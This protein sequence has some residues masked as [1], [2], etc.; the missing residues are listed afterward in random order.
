MKAT[1]IRTKPSHPKF[2]RLA[3]AGYDHMRQ[4]ES[5]RDMIESQTMTAHQAPQKKKKNWALDTQGINL[6]RE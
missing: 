1:H 4:N 5:L 2:Q 3:K 6:P